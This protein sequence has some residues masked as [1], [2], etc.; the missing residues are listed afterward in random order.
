[1]R[2]NIGIYNWC[3]QARGGG[4]K[5][6]VVMAEHLSRNH[7]VWLFAPEQSDIRA[8]ER[9]FDVDLSRVKLDT[10]SNPGPLFEAV[11]LA[12]G[13]RRAD[14][15]G[16]LLHHHL[17]LKKLGLD[18]FINSTYRS[19][20]VCPARRGIYMCMFPHRHPRPEGAREALQS[21]VV[22]AVTGFAPADAVAS[23]SSVAA[24]T[25]YTGGW[26][27]KLWGREPSIV[28]PPC[29][30]MGHPAVAKERIILHVGR[31]AAEKDEG[32]SH[33]KGQGV[34]LDTFRGL[35]GLHEDG[36]HLHFVGTVAP[37]EESAEFAAALADKARGV[38]VT[39]HF[40]ADFD[41]LRDLYRRAS[42]YWHATGY[43]YAADEYPAKQEHFGI[44]TVE[45][46]SAGAVP[47]VIN[48]GG[49]REIV[50][51]ESDGLLWDDLAGL[52]GQTVRLAG[53]P[54]LR[55][56]LGSQAVLSSR[57]FSREA[58]AASI[59]RVVESSLS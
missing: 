32:E 46:M 44:T 59:D 39:F 27:R 28:Y 55:E 36:W 33:H 20:L 53:D 4:E 16:A 12:R 19:D 45:A 15:S 18:L 34:L 52:A 17:Q 8:L 58:F 23:Y 29:D 35:T 5:L 25:R 40:A 26:V 50:T 14:Q 6:A 30:D 24:I 11:A 51:H 31:F 9:Y 48:S 10:L 21:G 56:R 41:T 1:M 42:I 38:P 3:M 37:N 57:R 13:R 54:G 2:A 49:Q 47:V 7:N 43:G 22:K